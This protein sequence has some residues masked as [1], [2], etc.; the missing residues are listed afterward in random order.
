MKAKQEFHNKSSHPKKLITLPSVC[1]CY[2]TKNSGSSARCQLLTL[3]HTQRTLMHSLLR[4]NIN[5]YIKY[6]HAL[7]THTDIQKIVYTNIKH[8]RCLKSQKAGK[9]IMSG[10]IF[11]HIQ[12]MEHHSQLHAFQPEH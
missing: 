11:Y 4:M 5:E 6:A 9:Y 10:S 12:M 8:G 1:P 2:I 7:H 3:G